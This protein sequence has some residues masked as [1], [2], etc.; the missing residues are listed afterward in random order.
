MIANSTTGAD[1]LATGGKRQAYTYA[2]GNTVDDVAWYPANAGGAKHPV[3]AKAANELG[4]KDM[5]GNV[6]EWVSDVKGD[7]PST[8]VTNPTGPGTVT[9]A[10]RRVQRGGSWYYNVSFCRPTA[11]A[12]APS[13]SAYDDCGLRLVK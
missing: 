8:A 11:R 10:A 7:Y 5:S 4:L 9:D 2:G 1:I 13:T 6:F 12:F 3:G